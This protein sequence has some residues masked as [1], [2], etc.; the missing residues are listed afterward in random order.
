MFSMFKLVSQHCDLMNRKLVM[1][2]ERT[3]LVASACFKPDIDKRKL[4]VLLP[5][6]DQ[7]PVHSDLCRLSYV[8]GSDICCILLQAWQP[9][10]TKHNN[11]DDEAVEHSWTDLILRKI[12]GSERLEL[13]FC[14]RRH[15][16]LCLPLL[17]L[18][19][20]YKNTKTKQKQK[21]TRST[22][23]KKKGRRQVK[24]RC[25]HTMCNY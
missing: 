18:Q 8:T 22:E 2:K 14:G 13:T 6:S 9:P 19:G 3:T 10:C 15:S 16:C 17:F 20:G 11:D 5:T 12:I 21:T 1:L 4:H 7:D 24:G 25:L 23:E